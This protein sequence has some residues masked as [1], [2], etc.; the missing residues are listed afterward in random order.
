LFS[1][2]FRSVAVWLIGMSSDPCFS[3]CLLCVSVHVAMELV[4]DLL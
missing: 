4:L 3:I 2:P 1:L